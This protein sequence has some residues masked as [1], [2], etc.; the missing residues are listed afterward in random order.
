VVLFLKI[1]K[2][3]KIKKSFKNNILQILN[4]K[5]LKNGKNGKFFETK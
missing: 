4:K 3:I 1:K 5:V 2:I